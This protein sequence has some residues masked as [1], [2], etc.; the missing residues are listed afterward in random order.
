MKKK[1]EKLN[2]IPLE[3]RAEEAMKKAVAKTI[4]DH[5]RTGDPIV[6]WRDGKVVKVPPDQI[7]V[8]EPVTEYKKREED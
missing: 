6:I 7:E 5:R 3:I 1:N 2:D 8:R 4:E